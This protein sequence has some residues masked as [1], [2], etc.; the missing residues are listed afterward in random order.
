MYYSSQFCFPLIEKNLKPWLKI[1]LNND[2]FLIITCL[3]IFVQGL[4]NLNRAIQDDIVAI[5]IL[6][7]SQWAAPS[8]LVLEEKDEELAEEEQEKNVTIL[9]FIFLLVSIKKNIHGDS[10][11]NYFS[12]S[13][14]TW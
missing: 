8:S 6:P 4:V 13:R 12:G 3:Q 11:P 5:E 14:T 1:F 9:I 2:F 7:E 10:H